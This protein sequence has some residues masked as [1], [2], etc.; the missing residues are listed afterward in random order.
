MRTTCLLLIIFLLGGCTMYPPAPTRTYTGRC[1]DAVSLNNPALVKK[2]LLEQYVDWKGTRYRPGGLSRSGVDCSGFVHITY[3]AQL[4]LD[5]PRSTDELA[6]IG[7]NVK[8]SSLLPGDL[9]FFKTGMLARHVGMYVDDGT[10]LHVSTR[11]GVI[12]SRLDDQYWSRRFWK[13]KRL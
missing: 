2:K 11:K 8:K 9:V 6:A 13:A 1:A 4:C 7:A 3:R 10:F 5:L 12:L